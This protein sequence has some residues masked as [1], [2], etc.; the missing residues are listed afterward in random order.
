MYVQRDE[1]GKVKGV[2]VNAQVGY[3]EEELVDSH[4][5]ILEYK[6]PKPLVSDALQIRLDTLE[7][8]VLRLEGKIKL[9]EKV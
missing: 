6:K 2:Y 3:A 4:P 9:L 5:D 8:A 7:T 1:Q